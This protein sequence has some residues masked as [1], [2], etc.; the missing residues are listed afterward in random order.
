M[1]VQSDLGDEGPLWSASPRVKAP[2]MV[3]GESF[4][5][6]HENALRKN[7]M[8]VQSGKKEAEKIFRARLG[9]CCFEE[10][11]KSMKPF[12]HVY[13]YALG[14][15]RASWGVWR[16]E[17]VVPVPRWVH[18][19]WSCLLWR[20]PNESE[21]S[22]C[23][24]QTVLSSSL[25]EVSEELWV[26]R[27]QLSQSFLS[28]SYSLVL[29]P[30]HPCW[31]FVSTISNLLERFNLNHRRLLHLLSWMLS[32]SSRPPFPLKV[33]SPSHAVKHFYASSSPAPSM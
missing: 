1:F 26:W 3:V 18:L 8:V 13:Y 16:G 30:P 7:A 22:S 20:N 28:T 6:K 27:P 33:F 9:K 10:Q 17:G 25:R 32:S 24:R 19:V 12:T 4:A 23:W 11:I 31:L 29:F 5:H 15:V 21:S 2:A 14:L